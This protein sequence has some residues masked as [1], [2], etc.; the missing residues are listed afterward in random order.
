MSNA[1]QRLLVAALLAVILAVVSHTRAD[2]DLWGHIRFGH[3]TVAAR[4]IERADPY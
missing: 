3:D 4:A 1:V 2:P